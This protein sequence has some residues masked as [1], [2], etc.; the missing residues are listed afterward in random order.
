MFNWL[1]KLKWRKTPLPAKDPNDLTWTKSSTQWGYDDYCS[2][3]LR[4][5]SHREYMA[6]VCNSC[7]SFGTCQRFGR[8]F[9]QIWNGEK[10]IWQYRYKRNNQLV[11]SEKK[12]H[13]WDDSL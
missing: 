13:Y 10:W 11:L 4:S 6:G 5:I 9:R 2:A 1:K 12:L 7:G 8:A 3:C